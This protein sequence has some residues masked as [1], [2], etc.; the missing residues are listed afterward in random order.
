MARFNRV[1]VELRAILADITRDP[2]LLALAQVFF[3]EF[4]LFFII[5]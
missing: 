3:F 4:I 1:D 2:R 5:F